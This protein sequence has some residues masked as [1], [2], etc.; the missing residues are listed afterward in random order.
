MEENENVCYVCGEIQMPEVVAAPKRNDAE[1]GSSMSFEEDSDF[2]LPVDSRGGGTSISDNK[3]SYGDE[4]MVE[5]YYESDNKF[6]AAQKRHNRKAVIITI[7]CIL[8]VGIIGV[9]CF[10]LF[11]GVFGG[12]KKVNNKFTIYFDKPASDIALK[13]SDGT[14]FH[15]T[16]DVEV[17]YKINNKKKTK[18]C[19][20]CNDHESLWKV[21]LST[22]ATSIYFYEKDNKVLRTQVTPGFVDEMVYYVSQER[23]NAHNQLPLGQCERE[24]FEGIGINYA[25]TAETTQPETTETS[26]EKETQKPTETTEAPTEEDDSRKTEDKG[27]YSVSLPKSWQDGVTAVKNKNSTTYYEDMFLTPTT[28]PRT[29]LRV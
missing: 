4:D 28:A 17:S 1:R 25:T 10:C 21:S 6:K 20:P 11:N 22:K 5:P 9:V 29:T 8:V 23:L 14:E 7:I 16:D 13:K 26:T 24:S 18:I 3:L 27:D 12:Q 19:T 15:W 2:V